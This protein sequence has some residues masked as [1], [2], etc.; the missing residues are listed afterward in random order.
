MKKKHYVYELY[1]SAGTVEYVG[2][3]INP[4]LRFY[5]HTKLKP[6]NRF[7]RKNY[8]TGKFYGRQDIFMQVTKEFN[9]KQKAFNFQCMLQAWYGLE[10]DREIQLRNGKNV[11]AEETPIISTNIKTGKEIYWKSMRECAR[12]MGTSAG[13]IHSVVN[14]NHYRKSAKGHIFRYA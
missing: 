11:Q 14:P 10:T 8:G 9:T 1:N 13:D 5:R 3:T 7:G 2:E 4:T 6:I 12:G